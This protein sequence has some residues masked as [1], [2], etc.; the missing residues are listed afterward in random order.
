MDR[1]PPLL[2]KS[3][4]VTHAPIPAPSVDDMEPQNISF[5]GNAAD[6]QLSEGKFF[7]MGIVCFPFPFY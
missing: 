6:E 4:S 3:S 1:E 5:I 2:R 7:S